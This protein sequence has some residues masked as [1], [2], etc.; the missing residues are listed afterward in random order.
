MDLAGRFLADAKAAALAGAQGPE[1]PEAELES[2]V[3]NTWGDTGKSIVNNWLG[4]VYQTTN[5][6]RKL[7]FM[8]DVNP[9]DPLQ[10][11]NLRSQSD[12]V[13]LQEEFM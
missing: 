10:L 5:L 9:E 2:L 12:A 11:C 1:F 4:L 3:D 13:G 6:E 7:Q 8:P